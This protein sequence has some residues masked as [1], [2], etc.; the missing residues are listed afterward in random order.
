MCR[1]LSVSR[2]GY[3]NWRG[4]PDSQR[5]IDNKRLDAHIQAIYKK[6]K[7]RYGSPKIADELNDMGFKVSNNRI[8]IW[9]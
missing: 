3:Y 5:T 8:Q 9:N 1:A 6:H 4:R 7:G 2:S